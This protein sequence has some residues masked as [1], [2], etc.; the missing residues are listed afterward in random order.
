MVTA[1]GSRLQRQ[2][3]QIYPRSAQTQIGVGKQ[4]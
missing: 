3:I 1:P 2:K 4:N